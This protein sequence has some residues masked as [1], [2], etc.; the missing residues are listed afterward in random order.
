MI[1]RSDTPQARSKTS[2]FSLLEV[3][4]SLLLCS[5]ILGTLFAI[6][7]NQAVQTR[8]RLDRLIATEFAYSL[9]E[10]YRVTFPLMSAEG[11]HPTGW[12]WEITEREFRPETPELLD[13]LILYVEV[14]ARVWQTDR[15]DMETTLTTLVAR[16]RS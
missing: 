14:I 5:L 6:I 11:N 4:V 15:P 8:N 16:P 7:P 2:G 10:E 9:L 3:L 13:D 12:S 1:L